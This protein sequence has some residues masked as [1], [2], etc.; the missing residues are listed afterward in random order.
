MPITDII[1]CEDIYYLATNDGKTYYGN[2]ERMATLTS[3]QR[4]YVVELVTTM[5]D[6]YN[7]RFKIIEGYD[8][9]F[10]CQAATEEIGNELVARGMHP[11]ADAIPTPAFANMSVDDIYAKL[12]ENVMG[13]TEMLEEN[14]DSISEIH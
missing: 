13:L 2:V 5:F 14:I 6:R 3:D 11:P 8:R 10:W 9:L 1:P 4:E 7:E 12:T